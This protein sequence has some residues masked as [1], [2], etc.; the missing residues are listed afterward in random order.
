M[1]SLGDRSPFPR[2]LGVAVW[3]ALRAVEGGPAIPPATG[4]VKPQA[5]VGQ[6][7]DP[8]LRLLVKLPKIKVESRVEPDQVPL[9]RTVRFIVRPS[10]TGRQGEVEVT[11]VEQPSCT[12][13]KVVSSS[14]ENRVESAGGEQVSV[15]EITFL[16]Q[17]EELGM[18]TIKPLNVKFRFTA[19]ASEKTLSTL[20]QTVQVVAPIPERSPRNWIL[21]GVL[22]G[23]GLFVLVGVSILLIRH[24]RAAQAPEAETPEPTPSERAQASLEAAKDL[25]TAGRI[26]DYHVLIAATVRQYLAEQYGL[27]ARE[28]PTEQLLSGLEAT[29][30][31]AFPEARRTLVREVLETCDL[32]KFAGAQPDGAALERVW[33]QAWKLVTEEPQPPE[34]SEK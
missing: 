18:A 10:W 30:L 15:Q 5:V 12:G 32:V 14:Q 6:A 26:K 9:N 28:Q 33:Q 11:E 2:W 16:L 3:M 22:I 25:R 24:H 20:Q 8:A 23:L 29:E 4:S 13:L 34:G 1:R 7:E 31:A 27:P 21:G 17:P 19:T